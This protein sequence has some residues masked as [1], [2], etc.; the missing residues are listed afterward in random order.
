MF[1]TDKIRRLAVIGLTLLLLIP[2][3]LVGT[4]LFNE[5]GG[6]GETIESGTSAAATYPATSLAGGAT[7]VT[8]MRVIQ[9]FLVDNLFTIVIVIGVIFLLWQGYKTIRDR[10][11]E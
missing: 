3:Y 9:M 7:T 8:T 4:L 1:E 11:I 6:L 10:D 2:V 5:S